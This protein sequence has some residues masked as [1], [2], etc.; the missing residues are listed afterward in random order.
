MINMDQLNMY[1][2]IRKD[3]IYKL[4]TEFVVIMQ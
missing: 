4:M 1:R 2:G 3:R